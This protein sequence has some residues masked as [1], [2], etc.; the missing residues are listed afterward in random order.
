MVLLDDHVKRKKKTK[1]I[2]FPAQL[3]ELRFNIQYGE[4]EGILEAKHNWAFVKKWY[5]LHRHIHT[6]RFTLHALA[7]LDTNLQITMPDTELVD[8]LQSTSSNIDWPRLEI[9]PT[10][11]MK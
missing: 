11:T 6:P 4:S 9:A 5:L 10:T 2:Y 8:G 1:W 7:I 3:F